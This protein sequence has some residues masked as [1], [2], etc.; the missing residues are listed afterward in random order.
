MGL[1]DG[2][3]STAYRRRR[4][5]GR[6]FN[7]GRL[8]IGLI[9]AAF[10]LVSYFGSKEYNPF[11]GEKQYLSMTPQQEMALGLQA[12]PEMVDQFGG[13]SNDRNGQM[14]VEKTGARLIDNDKVRETDWEFKFYL[15]ADNRTVN[16]F[17]LP[18]GHVFITQALFSKLKTEGQLAGVLGHEIGHVLA[19]HSAQHMAKQQLTQGLT[20]AVMAASGDIDAGRMA[21]LVGQMINMRYGREDEL[22][23]DELGVMLTA[24]ANYDPRAMLEVMRVLEEAGGRG[25]IEFFSTH[26]NPGNRR[27]HIQGVIDE[28]FPDGIPPGLQQ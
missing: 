2:N 28:I 23:S 18:G 24:Q 22:Q 15:L 1:F 5:A 13:L 14:L 12:V 27:E 19:R 26:P 10:S 20:G 21:A 9:I 8:F 3:V 16:A 17:A 11:T 6:S 25:P 7:S 4:N